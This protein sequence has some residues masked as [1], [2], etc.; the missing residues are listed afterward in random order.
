MSEE[1][2][3]VIKANFFWHGP[4][5]SLY[6]SA[7]LSSFVRHGLS[8]RLHTFNLQLAV[9]EGVELVDASALAHPDEV[10]AYT[11]GGHTASIAAFTDI[12]RYRVLG[13]EPGWWFDTDVFCL[14]DALHY[15]ALER[16][17]KGLLIGF[18]ET[19]KVNGA[20][21]YISDTKLACRLE[22]L[23]NAKGKQFEWGAI[24]PGLV[25]EYRAAHPEQVTALAQHYFYPIH[26]LDVARFFRPEDKPGCRNDA[27][28]AVC[29]HLW[30]E[31][32]RRWH[33]PKNMLPCEGS[34]LAELFDQVEA[35]T[36]LLPQA[37][38]HDTFESLRYGGEIGRLGHAAIRIIRR[39]KRLKESVIGR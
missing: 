38:P 37:L 20:V 36:L 24:G 11:Q 22:Q 30:N 10:L 8:V 13:H 12:F 21:M 4:T 35:R 23:A 26:Y 7:C 31:F 2:Y 3:D 39:V 19:E 29:V 28:N 16:Q 33:V 6:E 5:L 9:P 32:L 15:A 27:Q 34:Y 1:K 18:E 17:S 25:T 14:K